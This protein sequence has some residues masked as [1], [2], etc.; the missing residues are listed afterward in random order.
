M[1]A[2]KPTVKIMQQFRE[3]GNMVYDVDCAGSPLTLRISRDEQGKWSVEA[4]STE[5]TD[6][7]VAN[8]SAETGAEAL[9]EAIPAWNAAALT[10]TRMAVDGD[11]IAKAMWDVKA[12]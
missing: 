1:T 2:P 5:A 12:I 7:I 10:T 4:R 3:R 9:A 6:A 8:A 11:A